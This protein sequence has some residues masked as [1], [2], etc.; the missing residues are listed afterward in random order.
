VIPSALRLY[1]P[2]IAITMA[3]CDLVTLDSGVVS[4]RGICESV[5]LGRAILSSSASFMPAAVPSPRL[6]GMLWMTSLVHLQLRARLVVVMPI[7]N[8]VWE[9]VSR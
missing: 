6:V 1:L 3:E 2:G 7:S 5:M 8:R 9:M 4:Q